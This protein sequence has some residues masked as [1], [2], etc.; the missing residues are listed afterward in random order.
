MITKGVLMRIRLNI[1]DNDS[2]KLD[3][4]TNRMDGER[5]KE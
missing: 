4:S 2:Q 3:F 5:C 1:M